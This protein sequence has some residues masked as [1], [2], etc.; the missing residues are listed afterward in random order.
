MVGGDKG[1]A[2]TSAV[3][4]KA[5][6]DMPRGT[7]GATGDVKA[8]EEATRNAR[9]VTNFIFRSNSKDGEQRG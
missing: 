9:A 1:G 3:E 5:D 7:R 6:A 2:S 8:E 4:A